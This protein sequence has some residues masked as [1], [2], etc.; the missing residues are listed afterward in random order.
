MPIEKT[1]RDVFKYNLQSFLQ[2]CLNDVPNSMQKIM[3][4]FIKNVQKRAKI[5]DKFTDRLDKFFEDLSQDDISPKIVDCV[6]EESM[7]LTL[8][9]TV[10]FII[11]TSNSNKKKIKIE[12]KALKKLINEQLDASLRNCEAL[13]GFKKENNEN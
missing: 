11:N 13:D 9:S 6:L 12:I 8:K 10:R 2:D 7:Y 5:L 1:F 4:K 3:A